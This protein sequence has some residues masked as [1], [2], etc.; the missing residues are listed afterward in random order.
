MNENSK[1]EWNQGVQGLV[2]NLNHNVDKDIE[3][4]KKNPPNFEKNR[5]DYKSEIQKRTSKRFTWVLIVI[6]ILF[7]LIGAY[8]RNA[9]SQITNFDNSPLNFNNSS[10]NFDNSSLNFK[11]SPLNFDNSPLNFNS[12]NGIYDNR[13]NRIGYETKSSNGVTNFFDNNGYRT[14]YSPSKR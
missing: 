14:G 7:V 3:L 2:D 9:K 13:G 5:Q 6:L 11:N 4:R 1:D 12:T 10:L 8:S